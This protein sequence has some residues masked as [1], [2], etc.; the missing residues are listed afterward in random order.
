MP[1][2]PEPSHYPSL[3]LLRAPLMIPE[4]DQKGTVLKLGKEV[5]RPDI[6]VFVPC[7]WNKSERRSLGS[8]MLVSESMIGFAKKKGGGFW[9]QEGAMRR[10]RR[11]EFWRFHGHGSICEPRPYPPRTKNRPCPHLSVGQSSWERFN[12]PCSHAPGEFSFQNLTRA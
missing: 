12:K 4:C 7:A 8:E 11:E 6:L 5:E 1:L 10:R 2:F 9:S 3:K